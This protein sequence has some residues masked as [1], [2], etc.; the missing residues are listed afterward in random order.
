MIG[1]EASQILQGLPAKKLTVLAS[2]DAEVTGIAFAPDG[3][4]IT[5]GWDAVF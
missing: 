2:T 4:L 3:G 5:T 1:R